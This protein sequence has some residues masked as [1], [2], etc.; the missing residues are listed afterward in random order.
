[1]NDTGREGVRSF[2]NGTHPGFDER[3]LT[4]EDKGALNPHL[5]VKRKSRRGLIMV[6]RQARNTATPHYYYWYH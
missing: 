4:V 2:G 3:L 6:R 1:V 5:W